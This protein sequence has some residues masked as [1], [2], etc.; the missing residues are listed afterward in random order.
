MSIT[1]QLSPV[2]RPR[3]L[4]RAAL[5]LLLSILLGPAAAQEFVG[6]VYP[7]HSLS[8]SVGVPGVVAKV[9]VE[10]G[11]RVEAGRRAAQTMVCK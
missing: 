9:H 7:R 8:L 2:G 4:H 11:A 1:T 6:I 10:P 3:T 5:A